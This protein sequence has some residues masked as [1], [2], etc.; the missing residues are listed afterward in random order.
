MKILEPRQWRKSLIYAVLGGSVCLSGCSVSNHARRDRPDSGATD[1]RPVGTAALARHTLVADDAE[2][3]SG[4]DA[5]PLTDTLIGL[6]GTHYNTKQ[7]KWF[8]TVT[9]VESSGAHLAAVPVHGEGEWPTEVRVVR[10]PGT[11]EIVGYCLYREWGRPVW[12]FDRTGALLWK[13][14]KGSPDSV[15]VFSA[16]D[17]ARTHIVIDLNGGM[18]ASLGLDGVLEWKVQLA[19]PAWAGTPC[20]RQSGPIVAVAGIRSPEVVRI[21]QQGDRSKPVAVEGEIVEIARSVEADGCT[22]AVW[23]L[24]RVDNRNVAVQ[25]QSGSFTIVP[26][27][28]HGSILNVSSTWVSHRTIFAS[29]MNGRSI[30]WNAD[31][32]EVLVD[33]VGKQYN[34]SC[35]PFPS[36]STTRRFAIAGS[37]G[38]KIYEIRE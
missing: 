32:N 13:W 9:T 18:L 34:H 37:K 11:R 16:G 21:D 10:T 35:V 4:L 5:D 31:R 14:D 15:H 19:G 2:Q 29:F 24:G 25:F 7:K 38:M 23:G 30:V 3:W 36:Y 20:D 26:L 6:R 8:S 12:F 33:E 22:E 17:P 28:W 1:E 27:P